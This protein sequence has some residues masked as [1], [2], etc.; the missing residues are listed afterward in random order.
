MSN[1][2]QPKLPTKDQFSAWKTQPVSQWYFYFLEKYFQLITENLI[3]GATIDT[4]SVDAT[5]MQS[6]T[7]LT[8]AGTLYEAATIAYSEIC[9]LLEIDIEEEEDD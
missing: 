6:A 9:E 2:Q 8:R 4:D 7:Q 1:E 5:A 3:Q